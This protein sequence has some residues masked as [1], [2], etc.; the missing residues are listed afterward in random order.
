M[1]IH[2]HGFKEIEVLLYQDP[3]SIQK[4]AKDQKQWASYA[5]LLIGNWRF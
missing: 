1:F 5:I 2:F 4:N 3:P